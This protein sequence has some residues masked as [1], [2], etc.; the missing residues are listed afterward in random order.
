MRHA[1][2]LAIFAVCISLITSASAGS[3]TGVF[4][5]KIVQLPAAKS[6]TKWLYVQG[7]NGAIRRANIAHAVIEY[8]EDYPAAKRRKEP[9]E[10]LIQAIEVRV[11][12]EQ[13]EAKDGEWH[14][15]RVLILA[16]RRNQ[17][18]P[19]RKAPAVLTPRGVKTQT[20]GVN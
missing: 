15:T 13:D 12:A 6:R 17:Q 5:G 7:R 4:Q 10:S 14:A 19:N 3:I 18:K 16:P 2:L 1:R 20:A 9:A 8:D 11:T